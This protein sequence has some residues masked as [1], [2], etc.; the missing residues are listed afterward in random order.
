MELPKSQHLM[1]LVNDLRILVTKNFPDEHE[2]ACARVKEVL[3]V[4]EELRHL[5]TTLLSE[6]FMVAFDCLQT[7]LALRVR[8]CLLIQSGSEPLLPEITATEAK[9][10][11][12]RIATGTIIPPVGGVVTPEIEHAITLGAYPLAV[13]V[14]PISAAAVEVPQAPSVIACSISIP[15]AVAEALPK[16]AAKAVEIQG[17]IS[18]Q[19]ELPGVEK[20]SSYLAPSAAPLTEVD[21]SKYRCP[22]CKQ[23]VDPGSIRWDASTQKAVC[24]P[25]FQKPPAPLVPPDP[26]PK[27]QPDFFGAVTQTAK[28]VPQAALANTPTVEVAPKRRGRPRKGAEITGAPAATSIVSTPTVTPTTTV[29]P[30][31][32]LPDAPPPNLAQAQ[33]AIATAE[34]FPVQAKIPAAAALASYFESPVTDLS[35]METAWRMTIESWTLEKLILEWQRVTGKKFVTGQTD[36][37]AMQDD[38]VAC[39]IGKTQM[40]V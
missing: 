35:P 9:K 16:V 23:L 40:A 1:D 34:A 29:A 4:A 17:P 8:G 10:P 27:T 28:P 6:P 26:G 24:Q 5:R 15:V 36:E 32:T 3:D 37:A 33:Q 25:C 7:A 18:I 20:V 22:D 39:Y 12:E 21:E 13:E 14:P 2:A 31:Q 11:L 30:V 38:I 19:A